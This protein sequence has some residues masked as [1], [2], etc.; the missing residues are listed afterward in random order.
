[1]ANINDSLFTQAPKPVDGWYS[2]FESG[3]VRPY[4]SLAEV[5]STV[6]SPVR[7]QGM[8]F[9]VSV[10][11]VVAEYWY[12]GGVAD[13][14]L[15]KKTSGSVSTLSVTS[16]NGFAG[17]V[18]NATSTP[19]ITLSTTINGLLKGNG[20]ALQQ[21]VAGTDY[22]S[23]T[24]S[25][26]ALTGFPTFNQNTTG[27]AASLTTS[28]SIYGSN[29]NGTAD[30]TGPIIG[31]FGGTGINNGTR[32]LSFAGNLTFSGA[33]TQTFTATGNTSVTLPTTGT[34][35]TLSG[36]ETLAAKTLSSPQINTPKLNTTSVTGQVWTATDTTG[37][38]TWQDAGTGTTFSN[39]TV[40]GPLSTGTEGTLTDAA[41]ITWDWTTGTN[42]VVTLQANRTL[43]ISNPVAGAYATL[44]V[45]QGTGGSKTLALPAGSKVSGGGGGV[46]TLSANATDEDILT[47]YYNGTNFYVSA[48]TNFN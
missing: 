5:L 47:V 11:G 22:L 38:G 43:S 42:K 14:N 18:A 27:S 48:A 19:A 26:G 15:I 29:F 17:S 23:P 13:I 1:M 37:G 32:T 33:F 36:A 44:R 21:A 25:A 46:V 4:N 6:P 28:R 20:T 8:T 35:A 24:G 34:L 9:L 41:T 7:V 39:I 3:A 2:V 40:N 31:T 10:S 12:Y 45:I 30:L 16:A